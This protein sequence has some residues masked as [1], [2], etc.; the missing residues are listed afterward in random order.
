MQLPEVSALGWIHSALCTV[1]LIAGAV[2][3][4]RPKLRE[5][6]LLYWFQYANNAAALSR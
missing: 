5:Y 3:L 4:A 6:A 2:Q 1:A